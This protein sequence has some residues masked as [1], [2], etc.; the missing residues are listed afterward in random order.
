VFVHGNPGSSEDWRALL[1]RAGTLGRALAWDHPGYGHSV[2]PPSF[3]YTV[4]GYAGHMERVLD[5]LGVGRAHLVLH[6]FGGAWGLTWAARNPER[7]ASV[8]LLNTGVLLGY[9]WHTF[10]RI[11][12]IPVLGELFFSGPRSAFR[13]ALNKGQATPLPRAFVDRMYDDLDRT[14]SRAIL[15]LYRSVDDPAGN[16]EQLAA[17]LRPLDRP[18]L[19]IWGRRDPYLPVELVAAQRTVFPRA[20]TLLL[21]DAAHWPFVDAPEAVGDALTGFLTRQLTGALR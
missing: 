16:A 7:F 18:A 8:T 1:T 5:H 20:E 6:D 12:R 14:T 3:R 9:R 13:R 4:D 2:V 21:D 10:A 17:A 19:V 11:W 15:A